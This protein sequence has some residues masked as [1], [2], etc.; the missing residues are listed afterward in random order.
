MNPLNVFRVVPAVYFWS[1]GT[2]SGTDVLCVCICQL[3]DVCDDRRYAV[4]HLSVNEFNISHHP[5][6]SV[7]ELMSDFLNLGIDCTHTFIV[8]IV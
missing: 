4:G 3:N 7:Y 8:R 1:I 2:T 6:A 5:T